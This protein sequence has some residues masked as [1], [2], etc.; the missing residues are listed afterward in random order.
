MRL[1]RLRPPA[2]ESR[3]I[4][5]MRFRRIASQMAAS[6]NLALR[7]RSRFLTTMGTRAHVSDPIAH[8]CIAHKLRAQ[9]AQMHDAGPANERPDE[10]HHEID[11]VIG[12]QN[13]QI[14]NSRPKRIPGSQRLALFEIIFVRENA[15]LRAAAGARGIDDAG[16]VFTLACDTNVGLALAP[17]IFPAERAGEICAEAE[18]QSPARSSA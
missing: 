15:T 7:P 12:R 9:R 18:L 5:I 6:S 17:E 11:G 14:S 4:P 13:A 10:A 16:G 8:E 3:F 2:R 1:N